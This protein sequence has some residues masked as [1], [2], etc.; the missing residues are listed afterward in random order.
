M[1][2]TLEDLE[3]TDNIKFM[4][5]YCDVFLDYC[6]DENLSID[7]NIAGEIVDSLNEMEDY[8]EKATEELTIEDFNVLYDNINNIHESLLTIN[9]IKLFNT[10]H[11]VYSKVIKET[12][13]II[14]KQLE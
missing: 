6:H 9:D 4:I 3:I 10:I 1:K 2:N 8:L 7:G 12:M 14:V 5:K 11:I 13:E